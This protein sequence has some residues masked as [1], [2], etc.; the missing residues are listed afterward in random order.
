MKKIFVLSVM[1]F[2]CVNFCLALE[3]KNL[4]EKA[5]ITTLEEAL[6]AVNNNAGSIDDLY[7]LGLIYLNARRDQE[8]KEVFNRILG[9]SPQETAAKWGVAEALRREHKLEESENLLEEVTILN[10]G[11][12]PAFIS[13]AYIR[14]T[15]M[16]FEGALKYAQRAVGIG[17]H[18]LD[19]SNYVRACL[20][21][22]GSRGMLAY[23]GGPF[24]KIIDGTAVFPMLKKAESIQPDSPE[25]LFGLG[26]FY[27][28]APKF[29]GGNKEKAVA[30]LEKAVKLDPLFADIYVRLAQ[31]YKL[32]GDKDKYNIYLNKALEIDPQNELALDIKTGSCRFICI[33]R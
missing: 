1:L 14:Y 11:F 33:G 22:A 19:L 17:K 3:W 5:Q 4:H 30:Y 26:S 32:K 2:V 25:V 15:K 13:R 20:I 29:V 7:L 24:S 27:L 28:L 8:A 31:A 18:K 16:D 12:A 23:Y 21:I 10:P 9:I 6:S